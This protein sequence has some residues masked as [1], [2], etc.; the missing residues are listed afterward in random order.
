MGLETR[1]RERIHREGAVSF[2]EYME[3]ALYEPAEGFFTRGGGA[4]RAGRDFVTSPEVGSLFGM[5][6]ARALDDTWRRLGEPDPSAVVEAGAGSGPRSTRP[7]RH[8]AR[9]WS[10][11]TAS[12]ASP[13]LAAVRSS[14]RST[15]CPRRASAAWSS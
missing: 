3:L 7:T 13:S 10:P 15:T 9:S 1:I 5:V 2:A 4:G 8:S 14:R 6:I 11:T 12:R